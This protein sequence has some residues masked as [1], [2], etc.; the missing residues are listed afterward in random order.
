MGTFYLSE[1]HCFVRKESERLKIYKN[2]S[3]LKEVRV[4]EYSR[5]FLHESSTLTADALML[6][7]D[8]GIDVV[9]FSGNR[10]IGRCVG[11]ASRNVRLRI[12]QVQAHLSDETSLR[13][14][15][16]LVLATS[17]NTRT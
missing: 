5:F 7:G 13:L 1:P 9:Y 16:T 6:M 4:Q 14:A 10:M 12:A 2:R 11:A 15:R 17:K 3:L 8:K